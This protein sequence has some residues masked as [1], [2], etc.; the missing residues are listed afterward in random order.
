MTLGPAFE[1]CSKTTLCSVVDALAH[2]G[3]GAHIGVATD[4][5]RVSPSAPVPGHLVSSRS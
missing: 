4:L 5:H 2:Q 3:L 1:K